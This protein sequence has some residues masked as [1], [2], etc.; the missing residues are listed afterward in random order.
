MKGNV[1]RNRIHKVFGDIKVF[2]HPMYIAYDPGGCGVEGEEVREVL[3][4]R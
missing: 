1:I 3:R 2:R 4:V